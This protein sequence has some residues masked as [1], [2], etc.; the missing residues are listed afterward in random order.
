MG[1]R[2]AMRAAGQ[3]RQGV[4]CLVPAL[5]G[6]T[7]QQV[8][9]ARAASLLLYM[10]RGPALC[11]GCHA[12]HLQRVDVG[13]LVGRKAQHQAAPRVLNALQLLLNVQLLLGPAD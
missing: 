12:S 5:Q 9:G 7:R 8:H 4:Q 6:A 1:R 2:Q 11:V 13:V 3:I 10:P